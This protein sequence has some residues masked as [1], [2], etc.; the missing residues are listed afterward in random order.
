MAILFD[1]KALANQL[2]LNLQSEAEKLAQRGLIAGLDVILVGDDPASQTYV[3]NKHLACQK[4][5]IRSQIHRLPAHT[6][7]DELHKQIAACNAD[8]STHGVLLQLPLPRGL[9]AD[10]A[11][12]LIAPHKDVDGLHPDNLG[13]LLAGRPGLRPCT[14]QG[15]LALL[16]SLDGY[17]IK[18]KHAVVIGRS[19]LVGKPLALLLLERHATVTLCHSRTKDLPALTR[20]ADILIAAVGQPKLV[21]AHWLK[22]QAI[23]IDVGTNRDEQGRLV[24]DVDFDAAL[25]IAHA[26]TP[27]PGGVGPMTITML[28]ANTLQATKMAHPETLGL[29]T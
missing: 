8:P 29:P 9:D 18:G 13:R 5:G 20:Q 28:L 6:S 12:Q 22:P 4:I 19:I 27:V 17:D 14:P 3:H 16:D 11:L 23:V 24:G 1:G 26:I 21:Q 7:Q 25:P 10:A 15:C 2:R